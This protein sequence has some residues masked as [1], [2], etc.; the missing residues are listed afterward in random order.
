MIKGCRMVY[1]SRVLGLN[2]GAILD[3]NSLI[4]VGY[5]SQISE[6]SEGENSN[7]KFRG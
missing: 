6:F 2:P 3:G 5:K 1:L 4:V 7:G